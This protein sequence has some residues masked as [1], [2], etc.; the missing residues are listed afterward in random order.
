MTMKPEFEALR[1]IGDPI[2]VEFDQEPLLSKKPGVPDTFS[3]QGQ[4]YQIVKLLAEWFDYGRRGRMGMNMR[5]E[6]LRKAERRGSWGVGRYYFRVEVH[7]GQI[8]DMYYDRA[9]DDAG[10][11]QGHW[12]IWRELRFF[13]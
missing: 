4:D 8:F 7:S 3:W 12:F 13:E 6:H 9:P 1:F 5:P 11:R 10:D 2:I